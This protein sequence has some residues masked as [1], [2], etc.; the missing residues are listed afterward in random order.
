MSF[1]FVFYFWFFVLF[2]CGYVFVEAPI[3]DVG[4]LELE[5]QRVLSH[6]VDAGN[7]VWVWVLAR[8]SAPNGP[9]IS[10]TTLFS[11]LMKIFLWVRTSGTMIKNSSKNLSPMKL[12]FATDEIITENHGQSNWRVVESSPNRSTMKLLL[13]R[14]HFRRGCRKGW[15]R[16]K[17]SLLWDCVSYECQKLHLSNL[18][19]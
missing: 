18:T 11:F 19:D 13:R 6:H 15:N 2:A 8:T 9:A 3:V 12:L 5:L 17:A 10:A 4:S 16:G 7:W 14:D 1:V